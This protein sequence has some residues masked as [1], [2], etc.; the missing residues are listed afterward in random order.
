ML[1]SL[2]LGAAGSTSPVVW[3]NC[4]ISPFAAGP[5]V[6]VVHIVSNERADM[7]YQDQ[8]STSGAPSLRGSPN[9]RPPNT[10]D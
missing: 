5:I 2:V 6:V 7:L 3:R 1:S 9:R 8:C 4:I 10:K